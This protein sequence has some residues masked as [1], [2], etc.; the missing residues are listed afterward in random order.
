MDSP[1]FE[2]FEYDVTMTIYVE[3]EH[4]NNLACSISPVYHR[5]DSIRTGKTSIMGA[6]NCIGLAKRCT[7]RIL[8]SST[9]EVHGKSDDP[10]RILKVYHFNNRVMI[11][12]CRGQI[13]AE[14]N[15]EYY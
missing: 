15:K 5:Y 11:E 10:T 7:V 8:Q 4:I 1:C 12:I 13:I 3:V 14:S 6:L 9:S 2:F